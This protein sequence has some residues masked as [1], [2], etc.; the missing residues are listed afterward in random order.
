MFIGDKLVKYCIRELMTE[1]KP[2]HFVDISVSMT[3]QIQ[4]QN[5]PNVNEKKPVP[6]FTKEHFMVFAQSFY[7]VKSNC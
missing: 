7:P 3:F 2:V 5:Y 1:N 6:S 4:R